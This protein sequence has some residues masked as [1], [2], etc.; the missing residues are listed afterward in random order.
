M[1]SSQQG[2][3]RAPQK[4]DLEVKPWRYVVGLPWQKLSQISPNSSIYIGGGEG[5][6]ALRL[7]EP[8]GL[9]HQGRRSPPPILVQL[10]LEGGVLLSFPTFPFF[11]FSSFGFSF[12]CARQPWADPTY[13]VR[14]PQGPWALPG[15]WSP[16]PVKIRNPF[17]IP[18]TLPVMPENLPVTK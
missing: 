16:L 10:G 15:G 11:S 14:H 18:G 9:R 13:L 7:K 4:R 3:A 6:L 1:I 2:S 8:Q 12:S 5:R 17:V